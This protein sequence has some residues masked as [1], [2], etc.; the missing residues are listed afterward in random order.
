MI[1]MGFVGGIKSIAYIMLL[2]FLVSSY[3]EQ[4]RI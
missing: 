2:L 4:R 3:A 1:L